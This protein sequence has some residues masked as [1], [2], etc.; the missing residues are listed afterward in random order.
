MASMAFSAPAALATWSMAVAL[1]CVASGNLH[2]Y[3]G[4][5]G[6]VADGPGQPVDQE[7]DERLEVM[8]VLVALGVEDDAA[9]VRRVIAADLLLIACGWASENGWGLAAVGGAAAVVLALLASL[10]G[11]WRRRPA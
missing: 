9:V 8:P 4:V 7:V 10:A 5:G 6:D 3:P 2:R 1:L 11:R